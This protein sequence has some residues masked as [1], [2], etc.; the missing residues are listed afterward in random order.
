MIGVILTFLKDRGLLDPFFFLTS[1]AAF[2]YLE[3]AIL[4]AVSH[5]RPGPRGASAEGPEE[6]ARKR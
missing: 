6:I 5:R 2:V 1:A 3:W 4:S